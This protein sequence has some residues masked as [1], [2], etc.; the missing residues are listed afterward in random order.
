MSRKVDFAQMAV[1][2]IRDWLTEKEPNKRQIQTLLADSRSGVKKAIEGYLR[3]RDRRLQELARHEAMWQ[4]ERNARRQGYQMI[5]GIDEAGRGPLA[6][7][8]VA[9]AVILPEEIE[10][11]RLND[12]KQVKE[13]HREQLFD[14]I[15]S[16]A[17]AY[18]VGIVDIEYIDQHNILQATFEAARRALSQMQQTFAV[19]SDYLL[20][21]FLK[22]P[23]VSQPY[24][25]IVKGDASSYSIA[26]ASILA[27]VTRD[28]L[29]T[30][31]AAQYPQY[32]FDKNK[33]YMSPEHVRALDEHGPCAIHRQSFAPIQE[34]LQ[35]TLFDF[36]DL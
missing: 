13:E 3:Q 6:G 34:R 20:T 2:E 19:R 7:P 30:G 36:I 4:F 22:I 11:P 35:G 15:R 17:V 32:G 24:E 12:S 1:S 9:A 26:A 10:L 14:E 5:A 8:V 28:R 33:G 18:G 31:Y 29:M 25:A 21:D 16:C 27:K 23:D